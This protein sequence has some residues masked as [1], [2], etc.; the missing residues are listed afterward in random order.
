MKR[1][2]SILFALVFGFNLLAS[3]EDV[4]IATNVTRESATKLYL[5]AISEKNGNLEVA[6]KAE[7]AFEELEKLQPSFYNEIRLASLLAVR[8]KHS[9]IFKKKGLA[10]DSIK[11]YEALENKALN[12]KNITEIYEFHFFR[13][14]TY[15]NLPSM[16][17]KEEVAKQD[18]KTALKMLQKNNLQRDNGEKARLF[19]TYAII[20]ER[21]NNPEL[22]AEYAKKALELNALEER[23]EKEA[24]KIIKQA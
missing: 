2:F 19:L 1:F 24:K 23:D 5:Q 8:A 17:D 13:G 4:K 21:E 3:A 12:S 7:E 9:S 14:R 18:I 16:F 10:D 20:C 15:F 11:A 22:A 6:I